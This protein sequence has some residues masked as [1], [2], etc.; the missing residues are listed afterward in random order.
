M[1]LQD[2]DYHD[3]AIRV[4]QSAL[5][6]R[7]DDAVLLNRLAEIHE[8]TGREALA[9]QYYERVANHAVRSDL[10]KAADK[11]LSLSVPVMTDN[12]R[13]STWLAWREVFGICLLFFL[14]AFQDAGL[15][16]ATMN[17][18]R[19]MGVLLS[20]VGGYLLI[21]ATSS[22]QQVPLARMLGGRLPE[23]NPKTPQRKTNPFASFM[24]SIGIELDGE[25]QFIGPIEEPS[26]LPIIPEWIR[27]VFGISGAIMLLF[28]FYL[29][30]PQA[31]G[32]VGL[33][34]MNM[35]SQFY[36]AVFR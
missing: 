21:T 17:A 8:M 13:G 23:D 19:W 25:S 20:L 3:T 14:L 6:H 12:E 4:L 27:W 24:A 31:I 16:L 34:E 18:G 9:M 30:L 2:D 33:P 7:P 22:P 36:E 10:G 28:A 11:R 15:N 35:D 5:V 29:V 1:E 26:R 32:L